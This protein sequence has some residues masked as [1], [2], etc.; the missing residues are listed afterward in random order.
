MAETQ[1]AMNEMMQI[2]QEN[3]VKSAEPDSPFFIGIYFSVTRITTLNLLEQYFGINGALVLSWKG[4]KTDYESY[5]LS[6]TNEPKNDWKPQFDPLPKM[7]IKNGSVDDLHVVDFQVIKE[8]GKYQGKPLDG[9]RYPY[10]IIARYRYDGLFGEEFELKSFPFDCQDLQIK[11]GLDDDISN[12][13][14]V[15]SLWKGGVSLGNI[16][17]SEGH[18]LA[19][20]DI[21]DFFLDIYVNTEK[22][23]QK[24]SNFKA[25]KQSMAVFRIKIAR[26]WQIFFWKIGLFMFVTSLCSL[27]V[28]T[29]ENDS[30]LLAD[31]YSLLITLLLTAVAFQF[32]VAAFIPNLPYNTYLDW[33]ITVAF[34][35][36]FI[37][38]ISVVIVELAAIDD[39]L[40]DI[41]GILF[42][43]VFIVIQGAFILIAVYLRNYE[44]KKLTM[45]YWDFYNQ[46]YEK[47]SEVDIMVLSCKRNICL[48]QQL[49]PYLDGP[50][51]DDIQRFQQ[52][53]KINELCQCK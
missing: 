1:E 28:F 30:E 17:L 36:I 47:Q 24:E 6:K 5:Q 11:I 7:Q 16:G 49:K 48:D 35:I 33:Y 13:C 27:L 18:N 52:L 3:E 20:Y 43:I 9:V 2:E 21:M 15:P 22:T 50:K 25:R 19:E 34:L 39:E 23:N 37:M 42:S 10:I 4:T 51:F 29:M 44:T 31:K 45:T 8:G 32:V 12:Y 53:F 38:I 40:Y 46:E 14:F 26:K 41:I